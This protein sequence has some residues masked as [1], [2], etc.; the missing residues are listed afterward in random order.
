M[1]T[2][3]RFEHILAWFA[4]NMLVAE[5][6]LH[7]DN[8]FQLLVA[9]MLSAQCTDKRVN[10][11]SVPLFEKYHDIHALAECSLDELE[12]VVRP[13]GLYKAKAKNMKACCVKLESDFCGEIPSDM[14]ALLTLPGV[15]RK[16]ANLIRGDVFGLGGIVADTHMIRIA[17][18]LGFADSTDPRKVENALTPLI[19]TDEQSAFCHR[20]VHFGREICS[21]RA[22]KCDSCFIREAGLC[23]GTVKQ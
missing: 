13:C 15:G 23:N 14:K 12:Q 2:K 10:I 4:E 18:R 19:P 21:A 3:A 5:S 7:Y 17:N 16:I 6:E 8:P 20:A 9:V 22:P 11:I 1:T